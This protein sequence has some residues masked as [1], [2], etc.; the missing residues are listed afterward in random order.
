MSRCGIDSGRDTLVGGMRERESVSE[1]L[2]KGQCTPGEYANKQF[3]T[4]YQ[5]GRN[6]AHGNRKTKEKGRRR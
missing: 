5:G 6:I 4:L 3:N 2:S 1:R